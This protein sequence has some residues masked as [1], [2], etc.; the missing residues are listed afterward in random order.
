MGAGGES[1]ASDI[2]GMLPEFTTLMN[3]TYCVMI[4]RQWP[5]KHSFV[6]VAVLRY[7]ANHPSVAVSHANRNHMA[8]P[9]VAVLHHL[10]RR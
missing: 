10:H 2:L 6:Q 4:V 8:F 9:Q 5:L 3:C 1:S 7:M